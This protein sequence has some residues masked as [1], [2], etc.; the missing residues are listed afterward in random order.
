MKN[1]IKIIVIVLII[2]GIA[3]FVMQKVK[4]SKDKISFI[5]ENV[6]KGEIIEQIPTTGELQPLTKVEIGAQVSGTILSMSVDYNAKVKKGQA[7]VIIDPS[8]YQSKVTSARAQLQEALADLAQAQANYTNSLLNARSSQTEVDTAILDVKSSDASLKKARNDEMVNIANIKSS[9]AKMVKAKA[10]KKR[11]EELFAQDF[12]AATDKETYVTDYEMDRADYE[13]K[14]A[15][16]KSSVHSVESARIQVAQSYSKLN[17][18]RAKSEADAAAAASYK[19][20]IDSASAKVE[21]ARAN[22][23]QEQINLNYCTIKSPIDGIVITKDMEVGQTVQASFEAP[24]IMTLAKDLKQ[25]QI[26]ANVDEADIAHVKNGLNTTFTV[27]AYPDDKFKGK[28]TQVRL[29][30]KT[31]QGVVTYQVIIKTDNPD[32]KLKPGMTATVYIEILKK[33]NVIK[34]PNKAV[35]FTPDSVT[36]F[37]YP[38]DYKKE[39]PEMQKATASSNKLVEVWVLK[40]DKPEPVLLEVGIRGSEYF[41]MKKGSIKEGDSLITGSNQTDTGSSGSK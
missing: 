6:Q 24:K 41:E 18:A 28:V 7:I 30:S 25:M 15:Q 5:T 11:Y 38:K 22:L 2:A 4:K 23:E 17:T 12:V 16:W 13:A 9:Q 8:I 10:D 14:K 33:E 1:L 39:S 21:N 40:N 34:I 26:F 3:F 27:E 19:A 32:L 35:L 31:D 37:P 29:S 36:N 20:Q